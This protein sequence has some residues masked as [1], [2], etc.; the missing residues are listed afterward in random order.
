MKIKHFRHEYSS[1][2]C[3]IREKRNKIRKHFITFRHIW[4]FD[5]LVLIRYIIS[6]SLVEILTSK[7]YENTQKTRNKIKWRS[8][9]CSLIWH[10]NISTCV[11]RIDT[12][13]VKVLWRC[14]LQNATNAAHFCDVF[15][16]HMAVL[17][18]CPEKRSR[19]SKIRP[20]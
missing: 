15:F 11:Y 2:L 7:M 16:R 20:R 18:S 4:H 17:P 12:Y 8:I 19:K 1:I 6:E 13:S 9:T 3:K 5:T 10:I 14:V